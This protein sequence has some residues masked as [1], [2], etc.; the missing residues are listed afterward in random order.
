M[1]HAPEDRLLRAEEFA[2]LLGHRRGPDGK[3]EVKQFWRNEAAGKIGPQR[4]KFWR[5]RSV[6]FSHREVKAWFSERTA[7]GELLPRDQW[8]E[9]W[10]ALLAA[11]T[12]ARDVE[13]P[14]R[15][16]PPLANS[17]QPNTLRLAQR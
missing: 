17:S 10:A 4:I 13:R 7:A 12:A 15:M 2:E 9:R 16:D 1:I 5:S 14:P 11:E 6:R 3:V 8:R